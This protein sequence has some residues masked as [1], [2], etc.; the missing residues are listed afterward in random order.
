MTQHPQQKVQ[1]MRLLPPFV[2]AALVLQACTMVLPQPIP[3]PLPQPDLTSCHAVGLEGLVGAHVSLLPTNGAWSSVRIIK[4]GQMVTMDFSPTRLNV[5]V[6]NAGI[7]QSL[8]C[9]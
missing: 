6:D 8:A 5:R 4:P 1:I 7:I 9:G 3:T 2:L